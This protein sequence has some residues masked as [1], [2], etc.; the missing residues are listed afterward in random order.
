MDKRCL[1]LSKTPNTDGKCVLYVMSRDQRA[2]DNHALLFA[3]AEAI[4]HKLPLVVAFNILHSSGDRRREHYEFMVAGL[5]EVEKTLAAKDVPFVLTTGATS[6]SIPSLIQEL[7]PRSVY[8]DFSP[9]RGS[10]SAQKKIAR[11]VSCRVVVVDAHN[12]IPVWVLSDHEEFAAHTIRRKI[13]RA[14][15]DWCKEPDAL[16]KHPYMLSKKPSSA[17]W[18]DIDQIVKKVPKN[19]IEHDFTPGEAAA[20]KQLNSFI[21]NGFDTYADGRNDAS[22]DFQSDLSPYLHYGQIS[23]LRIVLDVIASTNAAPH[24]FT[25]LKMPSHEGKATKR[26]GIDAFVEELVVRKEL[27]DNFC[28][29]NPHYDTLNGAKD[30][31]KDTL[32]KHEDDPREHVYTL[33]QLEKAET[34]DELWNAAQVQLLRSGKIHGYMRMYW[35]KKILEWTNKPSTAIK[36]AIYLND[37]YHLDG[38]DSNGYVGVMWSIAGIH[39]RPWFERDVYGKIRYMTANGIAKKFDT[40]K[41]IE[42]WQKK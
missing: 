3:Q 16:K 10:R 25:S 38:G 36:H 27:S 12:I 2:H 28:F 32:A 40:K 19:G 39:D 26:D 29:Y 30:W 18:N 31:A 8:F 7:Q 34:H 17:T 1:E 37:S 20:K 35:A 13:H 41:Y 4:E 6:S 9:L 23:A 33:D 15:E 42:Q 22:Q 21:T 14:I 5:K 11:S 24:I